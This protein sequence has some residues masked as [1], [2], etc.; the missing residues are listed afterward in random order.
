MSTTQAERRSN[1][2]HELFELTDEIKEAM[3]KAYTDNKN[4][5]PE[6]NGKS[7]TEEKNN[8]R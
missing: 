3:K 2:E 5:Y 1:I 6:I 7:Q 8:F 4:R